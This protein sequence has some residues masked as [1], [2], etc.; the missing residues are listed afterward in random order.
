MHEKKIGPLKNKSKNTK[1]R[2]QDL[3]K[4]K[5][6][7][8]NHIQ[9]EIPSTVRVFGKSNAFLAK[10]AMAESKE[11]DPLPLIHFTEEEGKLTVMQRLTLA[12]ALDAGALLTRSGAETYRVEDTVKHILSNCENLELNVLALLTG[13]MVTMRLPDGQYL[14]AIKRIHDRETNLKIVIEVNEVSRQLDQGKISME[15]AYLRIYQMSQ[16]PKRHEHYIL[17][18]AC[19]GFSFTLMVGGDFFEGVFSGLGAMATCILDILDT[20]GVIG[21]FLQTLIK[22]FIAGL[23][24]ILAS[25]VFPNLSMNVMI[26]GSIIS[27]FPGTTLTNGIRDTMNGD[28]LTG[29]GNFL[30]ALTTALALAMGTGLSMFLTGARI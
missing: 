4:L 11:D 19:I 10:K 20:E 5:G 17:L 22:A 27:F 16:Y 9:R 26:L 29:A 6:L 30:S 21:N 7:K 15:D 12:T 8:K 2:K 25:K 3:Q 14:T 23:L 28:Y 1:K 13:L 18:S 24:M